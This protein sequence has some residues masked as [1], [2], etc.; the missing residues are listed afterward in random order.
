MSYFRLSLTSP[1]GGALAEV[2]RIERELL[3]FFRTQPGFQRG[4]RL[5]A[6]DRVGRA[7]VWDSEADADHAANQQH[8]LS[9]RS[10]LMQLVGE[11]TELAFESEEVLPG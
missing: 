8:T 2:E 10:R 1:H 5:T 9:L 4:F 7:T 11:D 3:A 6:D